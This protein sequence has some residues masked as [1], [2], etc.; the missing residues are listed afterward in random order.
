MEGFFFFF[1]LDGGFF[2]LGK[3]L[4]GLAWLQL[5]LFFFDT[6]LEGNKGWTGKGVKS[7]IERL[8]I[9]LAGGLS[10]TLW[11]FQYLLQPTSHPGQTSPSPATMQLIYHPSLYSLNKGCIK[12]SYWE[13]MIHS[14]ANIDVH[15]LTLSRKFI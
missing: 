1:F 15:F 11:T 5:L 12:N 10:L 6:H 3:A 8:F 7:W 4:Q 9:D 2:E 14:F 13:C